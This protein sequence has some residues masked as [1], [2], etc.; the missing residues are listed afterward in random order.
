MIVKASQYPAYDTNDYNDDNIHNMVPHGDIA[1]IK[2]NQTSFTKK[3]TFS[4]MADFNEGPENHH[5]HS[6]A[7]KGS[8]Q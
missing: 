2:H 8:P 4:R 5:H 1:Y 7:K 6:C 3:A